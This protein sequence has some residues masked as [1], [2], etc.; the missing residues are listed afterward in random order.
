[1]RIKTGINEFIITKPTCS[2]CYTIGDLWFCRA[3]SQDNQCYGYIDEGCP[4]HEKYCEAQDIKS[5]GR[6][7]EVS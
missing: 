6:S 7:P 2:D 1:M 3:K 4:F 5:D